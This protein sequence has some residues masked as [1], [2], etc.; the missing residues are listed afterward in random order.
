MAGMMPRDYLLVR[1]GE[2]EGNVV[3]QASKRG[4]NSHYNEKFVMTPGTQ[5]RLTETGIKQARAIGKFITEHLPHPNR[6]YV[7]PYVRTRLTAE[8][9][10]IPNAY[11]FL[12]RSYRER[13]WGEIEALPRSTFEE[14]YP[15][16]A[17]NKKINPLYWAPPGGE[18]I[19]D[20][21]ENRVR[22]LLDTLAREETKKVVL[23]VTHGENI[24]AHRLTIERWSDEEFRAHDEDPAMRIK[25]CQL[26]H[27]SR[28]NPGTGMDERRLAWVRVVT[29]VQGEDG[30]W[31]A[32]VT[33]PW[34]S[35]S[36]RGYSNSEL[37]ESVAYVPGIL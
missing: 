2:S 20:V 22:N 19:A 3:V 9:M 25:N 31:E 24:W 14:A 37:G 36:R 33:S 10:A 35:F 30:E 8:H 11:W 4:D 12:N 17:R 32:M 28:I 5:W 29:P 27:Y 26:V 15:N 34:R 6:F 18:S 1:H 23:A 7:S 16:S 13:E 21:G